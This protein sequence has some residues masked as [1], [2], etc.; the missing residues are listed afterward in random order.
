[1]LVAEQVLMKL[2][3]IVRNYLIFLIGLLVIRHQNHML[4][5]KSITYFTQK[6]LECVKLEHMENIS[7][8][9]LMN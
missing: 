8:P 4:I 9:F 2:M 6:I 3:I 5:L 1:M 7:L